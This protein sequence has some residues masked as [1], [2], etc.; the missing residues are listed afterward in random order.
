[1]VAAAFVVLLIAVAVLAPWLAPFDAE[2]FFDYALLNAP[3]S[4][5]TGSAST[6]WAATSSAAS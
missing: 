6:R 1:M 5:S 2:N 4:P 3:P